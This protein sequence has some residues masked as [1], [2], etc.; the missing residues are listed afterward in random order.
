MNQFNRTIVPLTSFCLLLLLSASAA[1][2]WVW[3]P[4]TGRFVN[5]RRIPKESPELQVE[6]ARSLML[7]GDYGKAM[8]ET[9]KFVD[10]YGDTELADE[11]Q[12]LRGEIKLAQENYV[13][14][15]RELQRVVDSY[16]ES[17]LYDDV[18]TMQYEVG[19]QLYNKGVKNLDRGSKWYT[20]G[21]RPFNKRPLKKAVD[22]YRMV[23]TNEP[24]TPQAAEAQYKIGESYFVSEDYLDAALEYQLLLEQYPDSQW[25]DNASIGLIKSYEAQALPPAYDQ[26]TGALAVQAID[27]HL[28]RFPATEQ[29]TELLETRQALRESIAQQRLLTAEFYL[30]RQQPRSARITLEAL[31]EEFP[32]T[33]AAKE[34]SQILADMP[35]DDSLLAGFLQLN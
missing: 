33:E 11:N 30:D 20:F 6:H 32:D 34:A 28:V 2:Q 23:K 25:V 19:N 12:F 26:S 29:E 21:W 3:T 1:A 31:V 14:A 18:I 27:D 17:D 7:Q 4:Q 22:I 24:F 16:P 35:P 10:F 5:L 15:A 13:D 9:E 8:D